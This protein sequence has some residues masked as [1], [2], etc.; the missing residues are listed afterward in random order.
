ML[1]VYNVKKKFIK[2]Q[3]K[4]QKKEFFANDGISFEAHEG[5]IVNY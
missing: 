5:E 4:G 2:Y 3:E 1:K